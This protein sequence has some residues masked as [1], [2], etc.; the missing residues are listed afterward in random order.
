MSTS[1]SQAID[2]A[3]A[4]IWEAKVKFVHVSLSVEKQPIDH[5]KSNKDRDVEWVSVILTADAGVKMED[6]EDQVP[7]RK[8]HRRV[9]STIAIEKVK[10]GL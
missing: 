3:M 10:V 7:F 9:P 4:H 6:M 5:L 1:A 8:E 2:Q